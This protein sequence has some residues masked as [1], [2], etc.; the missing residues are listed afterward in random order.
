MPASAMNMT[1]EAVKPLLSAK[2]KL[3]GYIF[4]PPQVMTEYILSSRP[5][6]WIIPQIV[7][8]EDMNRMEI[9]MEE[10]EDSTES[11]GNEKECEADEINK[12]MS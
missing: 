7:A 10:I 2:E 1:V 4:V 3:M 11:E 12:Q 9:T 6:Q 8:A 5:V